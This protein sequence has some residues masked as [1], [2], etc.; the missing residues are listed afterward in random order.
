M[1]DWKANFSDVILGRGL[2]YCESN[3]VRTYTCSSSHISAQVA[4]SKMYNVSIY[5]ENME[6]SSMYCDCPYEGNCKHIAA[7]LYYLD[8]HQDLMNHEDYSDLISSLTY[9]ELVEFLYEELPKNPDLAN[10]LKLLKNHEAD[11]RGFHDKL[12]NCFNSPVRVIDFMNE[13]LQNLKNAKQINLLLSLLKRIVDY[14]AELN[15]YG[16]YDAYDD[17]LDTVESVINN[18]L[19][20]GYEKQTCDFLEEFILNSEDECVLDV[21]TDTYSRY[22][23]VEELF[24]ANFKRIN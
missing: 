17:V 8:N 9:D 13:D 22:R 4:G 15:Y 7:T 20:L 18:L 3:A 1:N 2:E 24:D 10:K 16:Q 14:L 21:F 6:I 11:S 23:S 5:F 19:D 12:E